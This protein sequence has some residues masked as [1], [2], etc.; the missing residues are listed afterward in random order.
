MIYGPC[1]TEE[2]AVKMAFAAVGIGSKNNLCVEISGSNVL[3]A[4]N[5]SSQLGSFYANAPSGASVQWLLPSSWQYRISGSRGEGLSLLSVP[6]NTLSGN[7]GVRINY[8]GKLATDY[9]SFTI[10]PCLQQQ[11]IGNSFTMDLYPNP[12]HSYTVLKL[13][14]EFLGGEYSIFNLEGKELR[15]KEN[16]S[17]LEKLKLSE[18]MPGIYLIKVQKGTKY[19]IQKLQITR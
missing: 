17:Q 15:K 19:H 12:A 6:G 11:R 18:L 9:F 8:Q 3:L 4:C 16:I 5:A 1:S 14:D 7:I 2:Y 10:R 13:D